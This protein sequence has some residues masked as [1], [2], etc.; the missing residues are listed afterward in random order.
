MQTSER[1]GG[2]RLVD[3]SKISSKRMLDK[4][5]DIILSLGIS[6]MNSKVP[7]LDSQRSLKYLAFLSPSQYSNLTG[8]IPEVPRLDEVA[9]E[10]PLL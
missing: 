5:V 4:T 10:N 9:I 2:T 7:T 1:W 8:N 6:K 3:I